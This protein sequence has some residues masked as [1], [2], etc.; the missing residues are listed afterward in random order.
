LLSIALEFLKGMTELHPITAPMER[1]V[2]SNSAFV[3]LGMALERYTG[4]NYTQLVEEVVADPLDL[5]SFPSPGVDEKAVIPPV[6]S[7]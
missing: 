7:T 6:D 1:P 4:K 5:Q 3:I 2:Y